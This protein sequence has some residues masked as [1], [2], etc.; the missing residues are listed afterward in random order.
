[1]SILV[2]AAIVGAMLCGSV[3]VHA[4]DPILVP[5]DGKPVAAVTTAVLKYRNSMYVPEGR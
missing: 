2:R 4:A 3:A 1:M 5:I